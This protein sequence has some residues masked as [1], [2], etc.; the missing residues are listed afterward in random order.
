MPITRELVGIP[1]P[2]MATLP[3]DLACSSTHPPWAPLP[4]PEFGCHFFFTK[5]REQR[6]DR[7]KSCLFQLLLHALDDRLALFSL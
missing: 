3:L 6:P 7:F 5:L 1:T 4:P 2:T